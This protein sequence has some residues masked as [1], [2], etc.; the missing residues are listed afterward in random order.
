MKKQKSPVMTVVVIVLVFGLIYFANQTQMFSKPL[1]PPKNPAAGGE[2]DDETQ[3]QM[4]KEALRR[5]LASTSP[6]SVQNTISPEAPSTSN[7]LP[8]EP[9]AF[10]PKPERHMPIFNETATGS[11]WWS[12]E[13]D[14]KDRAEKTRKERGF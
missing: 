13:A 1:F 14:M 5:S 11:Q 6:D 12:E 10:V 2:M 9:A 8:P 4:G 7:E 3:A